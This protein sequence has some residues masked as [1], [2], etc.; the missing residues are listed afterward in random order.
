MA[1]E[2]YGARV[3]GEPTGGSVEGPTAGVIF[4]LT[5]PNSGIKVR[6]PGIRS[7]LNVENPP[8]GQGVVP[9]VEVQ[10][11]VDDWLAGRDAALEAALALPRF[12]PVRR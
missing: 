4:V 1:Q 5:L 11:T 7:W 8:P 10:P 12:E 3:V 6:V 9:D 2:H